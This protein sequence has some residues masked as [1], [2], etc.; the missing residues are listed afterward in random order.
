MCIDPHAWAAGEMQVGDLAGAGDKGGRIFGIDA[1][2]DGMTGQT[3]LILREIQRHSCGDHQLLFDEIDPGNHFG[4]R[5]F[6]LQPGVHFDEIEMA[7]LVQ[8]LE[9]AR[10]PIPHAQTGSDTDGADLRA[11][12]RGDA[13]GRG[14]LDDFLVAT[15]HRAVALPQIHGMAVTV[16]QHLDL[17]VARVLKEFL[18]VHL[19]VVEC[20]GGLGA[21]HV[22]GVQQ[23]CFGMDDAQSPTTTTTGR[24]DDH[25][26]A[27]VAPEAQI[28]VGVVTQRTVGA[29]YTR[30]IG[31]AHGFLGHDLVAHH[32]DVVG[33]RAD[34]D[35]AG[36]L[37]ALGEIGIFREE[38]VAGMNG[39]GIGDLGRRNDGRN[40]QVAFGGAWTADA[41][42]FVGQ[43]NMLEIA[44]GGR[45]N[46]DRA[47]VQL[48]TGAQDTE[49]NLAPVGDQYFI[50]HA[51]PRRYSM[52]NSGWSNSTGWPFSTRI[53]VMVPL[54]SASIWLNI[55]IASMTQRVSPAWMTLPISTKGL[56]VGEAER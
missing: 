37:D 46:R 24:L 32:P 38:T 12:F 21:G 27:D 34:K 11:L 50:Q 15:L 52:M 20:G 29:R 1:A 39:H 47:N 19:R 6:D 4:D 25:G 56:A 49:R 44:V 33:G 5:V 31:C 55:F 26:V 7:V 53:A 54:D 51:K 2:F 42:R 16:G 45:V 3:D 48:T 43:A 30:H 8:K 36:L 10:A 23:G 9:R 22:D 28:L 40:I 13:G 41:D 35:E 18:H 14:F 17:D